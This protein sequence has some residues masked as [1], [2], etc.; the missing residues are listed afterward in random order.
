MK[1]LETH[2]ETNKHK[3]RIANNQIIESTDENKCLMD[4]TTVDQNTDDVFLCEKCN[5]KCKRK[6]LWDRHINTTKHL[7]SYKNTYEVSDKKCYKCDCGLE[8][9]HR[10]S[11]YNHK[12]KC[13]ELETPNDVEQVELKIQPT[14]TD[15]NIILQLIKQNDDFKSLI[16]EQTKTIVEQNTKMF[17][18]FSEAMKEM[19]KGK[20]M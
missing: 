11:L 2:N 18:A 20:Y 19:S 15:S 5:F 1:G 12:K 14:I 6:W 17:D 4:K 7:N 8:Y 16:I 9:S 13:K 10:Q 3:N